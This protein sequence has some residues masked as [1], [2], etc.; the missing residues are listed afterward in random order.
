MTPRSL[1]QQSPFGEYVAHLAAG[2]LA[3]QVS[4]DGT[5]V[6][7]P[8]VAA[9]GTGDTVLEWRISAGVGT[10]YATTAMHSKGEAPLNLALIDMDEGFRLMSRVEG[11]PAEDVR[12][13]LRVRF[14]AAPAT[15]DE[16]PYPLFSPLEEERHG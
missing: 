14:H 5:P 11:L 16:P 6:F 9:P 12:I 3:Y 15:D 10:V 13:G 1:L 2:R 4:R 7:Y 8:R